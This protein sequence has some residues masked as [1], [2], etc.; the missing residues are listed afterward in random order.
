VSRTCPACSAAVSDAAK[1]CRT[2]GHGV[3]A[4]AAAPAVEA[5]DVA[6]SSCRACGIELVPGARFCH[7]CAAE[8]PPP[9]RPARID[10]PG[11][12]K[13]IDGADAFCRYC[14]ATTTDWTSGPPAG[15]VDTERQGAAETAIAEPAELEPPARSGTPAVHSAEAVTLDAEGIPKPEQDGVA[16]EAVEGGTGEPSTGAGVILER[17]SGEPAL[18]AAVFDEESVVLGLDEPRGAWPVNGDEAQPVADDPVVEVS[19][20]HRAG[21]EEEVTITSDEREAEAPTPSIVRLCGACQQPVS[22]TGHFCRSCGAALEEVEATDVMVQS[23]A[24]CA[25]CGQGVEVWA[26]F[27]RHCGARTASPRA[28]E[29]SDG[30]DVACEVCGAPAVDGASLCT[31]CARVVGA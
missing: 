15:R 2:C 17:T 21:G 31:S 9:P 28:Q 25:H 8:V 4:T 16:D 1:F 20:G 29:Q 26:Q 6:V 10:C 5:T 18:A 7:M 19:D 11:C 12:G 30:S 23:T 27:C 24:T 14:G 3:A 22:H 13:E